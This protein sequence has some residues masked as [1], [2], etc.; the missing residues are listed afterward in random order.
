LKYP[1]GVSS[2]IAHPATPPHAVQGVWVTYIWNGAGDWHFSFH[3][4]GP[5]AALKLP[6][7]VNPSRADRLWERTCFEVFLIDPKSGSYFEFNFSPSGQWA[8][9]GFEAYRTGMRELP[10]DTPVQIYTSN[11]LQRSLSW[12]ARMRHLGLD[13]EF[14]ESMGLPELPALADSFYLQALCEGT[15]LVQSRPWRGAVSAVIEELDGTKS[16]WALAHP[17]GDPDFHH[18]ESFLLTLP[19]RR[20]RR[21]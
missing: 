19:S 10:L 7:P 8:A 14:I 2:L 16:Y 13:D 15:G 11:A 17:P 21:E 1:H 5:V 3:V 9:Y 6:A 18:A 12:E 4:R 20:P